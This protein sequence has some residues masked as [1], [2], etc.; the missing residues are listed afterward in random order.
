M[1]LATSSLP[2]RA[3]TVWVWRGLTLAILAIIWCIVAPWTWPDAGAMTLLAV[4]LLT[5]WG[6]ARSAT[7]SPMT[8]VIV[9]ELMTLAL[10]LALVPRSGAAM[11]DVALW[12]VLRDGVWWLPALGCALLAR[13]WA[14][15]VWPA[16][17]AMTI[18]LLLVVLSAAVV[19]GMSRPL[20]WSL[21]SAAFDGADLTRMTVGGAL[22]GAVVLVLVTS[23]LLVRMRALRLPLI[24]QRVAISAGA[25]VLVA[26]IIHEPL[27]RQIL[28]THIPTHLD[29]TNAFDPLW[30]TLQRWRDPRVQP[31]PWTERDRAVLTSWTTPT[32]AEPRPEYADLIGRYRGMNVLI[33]LMESFRAEA[34]GCY[35][36]RPGMA[37]DSP[38]FDGLTREGLWFSGHVPTGQYSGHALWSIITG[39]TYPYPWHPLHRVAFDPLRRFA[40]WQWPGYQ[41]QF[42]CATDTRF[43]H[44]DEFTRMAGWK[45]VQVPELEPHG[46]YGTHDETALPWAI[47]QLA[48]IKGPWIGLVFSVSNHWP[49]D[50]PQKDVRQPLRGGIRYSDH[51][52]GLALKQLRDQHPK[53]AARTIVVVVGDH[54]VRLELSPPAEAADPIFQ[55]AANR[56][57]MLVLLP[58]GRQAGVRETALTSHADIQPLLAD[59]CGQE[60]PGDGLGRSPLRAWEY[61][62]AITGITDATPPGM[63]LWRDERCDYVTTNAVVPLLPITPGPAQQAWWVRAGEQHAEP[64]ASDLL[65]SLRALHGRTD[66]RWQTEP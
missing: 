30:L 22:V 44:Y 65:H 14:W 29:A 1:D 16:V 42:I 45:Q 43:D 9:L 52:L 28:T 39:L 48:A 32:T 24:V 27:R 26:A 33:L 51:A 21:I 23:T 35:D 20:D 4:A 7:I 61:R 57:P 6:T 46:G 50:H 64:A 13:R 18:H 8:L 49:F 58:D 60:P 63:L 55:P 19:R 62:W 15:F 17:I 34:L 25:L 66:V 10:R 3:W 59:L 31:P 5:G 38:V 11:I 56:V 41:R 54:G 2:Q 40:G 12:S 53:I 36:A 47:D 37:S